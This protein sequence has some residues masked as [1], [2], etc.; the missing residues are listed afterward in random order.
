MRSIG[1]ISNIDIYTPKKS[2]DAF[3]KHPKEKQSA[4]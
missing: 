3:S 1:A 2:G 4:F